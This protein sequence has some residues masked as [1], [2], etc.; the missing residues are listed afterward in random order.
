M[1]RRFS[2]AASCLVAI[3]LVVVACGD[4]DGGDGDNTGG[5]SGGKGGAAGA[6][7]GGGG[8]GGTGGID[9]NPGGEGGTPVAG[10]SSGGTAGT[11]A[12][13]GGTSAG[14]AGTTGGT[15][16]GS[17]GE[18]GTGGVIGTEDGGTGGVPEGGTGGVPEEGLGGASAGQGGEGGSEADPEPVN[19]IQNPSFEDDTAWTITGSGAWLHHDKAESAH[20]GHSYLDMWSAS[21]YTAT[22]SQSITGVPDGDYALTF[23]RAGGGNAFTVQNVY[24]KGHDESNPEETVKIPTMTTTMVWPMEQFTLSPIHVTSGQLEVG[25][26]SEGAADG[27]ANFDDFVL[28]P[29]VP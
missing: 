24:V 17:A 13:S 16:P 22:V 15:T 3:P 18:G 29:I 1:R 25:I 26:Y 9:G 11:T 7:R 23:W 10:S 12:G 27:W 19:L 6:P 5:V 21:A 28:L 4:D 20:S 8:R 2:W 14:T